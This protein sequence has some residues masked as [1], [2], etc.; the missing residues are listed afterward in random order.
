MVRIVMPSVWCTDGNTKFQIAAGLL[1][2][3]IKRFVDAHPVYRRRLL[4]PDMEPVGH[5]N[6]CVDDDL[7]PRRSRAT[8]VVP[9]GSTVTIIPPM[10]GG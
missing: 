9:E 5:I 6:I 10:A 2:D 4:G 1:P 7:I 8:T 3:V